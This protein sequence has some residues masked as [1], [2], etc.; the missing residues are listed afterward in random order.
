M[1]GVFVADLVDSVLFHDVP[2]ERSP[3]AGEFPIP[4]SPVVVA[5]SWP[6]VAWLFRSARIKGLVHPLGDSLGL[7][8]TLQSRVMIVV[9]FSGEEGIV[10]GFAEDFGPQLGLGRI[11][12]CEGSPGIGPLVQVGLVLGGTEY[13]FVR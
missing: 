7:T 8:E 3:M 10:S 12:D 1:S 2:N 6:V 4:G 11:L 5:R 13:A 9:P